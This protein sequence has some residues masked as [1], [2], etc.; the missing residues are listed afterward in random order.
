MWCGRILRIILGLYS[1]RS[2]ALFDLNVLTTNSDAHRL[3]YLAGIC[4]TM[5]IPSTELVLFNSTVQKFRAVAYF[6]L[7]YRKASFL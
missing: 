1:P 4:A 7:N 2:N 5:N 6:I 3:S